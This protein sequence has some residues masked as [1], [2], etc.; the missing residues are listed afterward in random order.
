MESAIKLLDASAKFCVD[1]WSGCG[2][3]STLAT[4]PRYID[5]ESLVQDFWNDN[6]CDS[7]M[8][9]ACLPANVVD[10]IV[11][12]PIRMGMLI[13]TY[14]DSNFKWCFHCE[15]CLSTALCYF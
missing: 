4:H 2:T 11:S 10:F 15:F 13:Y 12:I 9:Q 3:L 8:L 1:N 7:V 6:G 14:M 5:S